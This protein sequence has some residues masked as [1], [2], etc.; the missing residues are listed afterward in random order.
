M[1]PPER[2]FL[3]TGVTQEELLMAGISQQMVRGSGVIETW[4][5]GLQAEQDHLCSEPQFPHL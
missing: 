4:L 3:G 1:K 5:R 2:P